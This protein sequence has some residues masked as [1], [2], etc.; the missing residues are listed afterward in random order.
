MFFVIFFL[1]RNGL[2]NVKCGTTI[3]LLN[4]KYVFLTGAGL[5]N[6]VLLNI[7]ASSHSVSE[8]K[9]KTWIWCDSSTVVNVS[10]FITTLSPSQTADQIQIILLL[11]NGFLDFFH[12]F[13]YNYFCW[14]ALI[15]DCMVFDLYLSLPLGSHRI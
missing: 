1:K 3:L 4:I 15:K 14:Y 6:P 13:R 5:N 9:L 2:L 10:A 8:S 7:L 12:Y 11:C